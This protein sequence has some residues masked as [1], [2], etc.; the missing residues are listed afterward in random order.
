MRPLISLS[1]LGIL[2]LGV[3]LSLSLYLDGT[4]PRRTPP[5]AAQVGE[6]APALELGALGT[7]PPLERAMLRGGTGPDGLKLVNFWAS[8]CTPC[9]AEHPNLQRLADAG[10]PV[11]GVNFQ[12]QPEDALAFLA[13]LGNPF[14]AVGTDRAGRSGFDWGVYGLPET[15][16]VDDSGT[17]LARMKG[18]LTSSTFAR[19]FA[20]LLAPYGIG[21][22]ASK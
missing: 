6:P 4:Q 16:L 13:E 10:L 18:P 11:Y 12:D 1:L 9:R 2:V 14:A 7:L 19:E 20:P 17:I 8:W 15:Y 5:V 21:L 22:T 3:G